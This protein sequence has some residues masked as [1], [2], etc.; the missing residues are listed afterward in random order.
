MTAPRRKL[1]EVA[2]PL[3]AINAASSA[4]KKVFHAHPSTLHIWWSRK[5]LA[6][7]RAVLF[8]SLVDDPSAQPERFPTPEGQAAERRR[9][10]EIIERLVPWGSSG[11][12]KVLAE[13]RTEIAASCGHDLPV[14]L[15]PFAGGGSIPLEAQRL[16]LEAHASDL[17]PVAVLINK[18]QIEVPSTFAAHPPVHPDQEGAAELRGWTGTQGLA[19]DLGYY[20]R[21]LCEEA[22]RRIGHLYPT[23]MLP[24]GGEARVIAWL[25]ARTVR[26][27]NPACGA[28]MPLVS[29][30]WLSNRKGRRAWLEP[31]ADRAAGRVHFEIG[32]GDGEPPEGPKAGRGAKFR[33]LCCGFAAID[34]YVKQVGQSGAM[35]AQLL[36][37]VAGADRR[38]VYLPANPEHEAAADFARLVDIPDSTFSANPRHMTVHAYGMTRWADL[39]TSRQLTALTTLCDLVSEAREQVRGDALAAGWADDPMPLAEGG[40]G[41]MAYAEAVS[42]YLAFVVNR[43]A[44]R[45]SSLVAWQP[46]GEKLANT[47][48][49]Q[50]LAMVW[51]F[52]EANPFSGSSGSLEVATAWV[53]NAL[54]ALPAGGA[55]IVHQQDA[56]RADLDRPVLISTDPP[57]YDNVPYADLSD[58]FYVWLRRCVGSVFPD[59]CATL[60]APKRDELVVDFHRFDGD[61]AQANQFFESGLAQV[62]ERLGSG[63]DERFPMTIYY[64]F[65]QAETTVEGGVASTGW[66]TMLQSLIDSGLAITATWPMRTERS[67]RPRAMEASGA[68]MRVRTALE[69][70]DPRRGRRRH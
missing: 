58:F 41:A 26:C 64:A 31:V 70:A 69:L 19:A 65:K 33:C 25:W 67:N 15:D 9:L 55:G 14:V 11:D 37:I 27:P 30:L 3:D 49:R 42:L 48:P 10:F 60:T 7:A 28:I 16:G 8:A 54:A 68:T 2:L 17:N 56:A 47:F 24:T 1:I 4:E 61:K 6:A 29:S 63:H 46:G 45:G 22:E 52:A 50:A 59:V 35:G 38:R 57:Y 32:A 53:A 44:D 40:S 51:N 5:P 62:F 23:V 36:A 20:S 34:D 21:W 43:V 12:A 66:E 13:A 18:A 39:F